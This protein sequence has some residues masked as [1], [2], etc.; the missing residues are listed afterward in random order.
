MKKTAFTAALEQH[1]DT[2]QDEVVEITAADVE[3]G[4]IELANIEVKHEKVANE[5]ESAATEVCEDTEAATTEIVALESLL[6]TVSE[7]S[8]DG[9]SPTAAR[10]MQA[11]LTPSQERYNAHS[12]YTTLSIECFSGRQ[13]STSTN[14]SMEGIKEV[15]AKIIAWVKEKFAQFIAWVKRKFGEFRKDLNVLSDRVQ[16]L[17]VAT[18][19]R[20][21]RGVSPEGEVDLGRHADRIRWDDKVDP[22][23]ISANMQRLGMLV[24]APEGA[25]EVVLKN[26]RSAVDDSVLNGREIDVES[27]LH[28]PAGW[29]K[30]R[31]DKTG[32]FDTYVTYGS[33]EFPG[34]RLVLMGVSGGFGGLSAPK[35]GEP[36]QTKKPLRFLVWRAP[37]VKALESTKVP[38]LSTEQ[39]QKFC[40][41]ADGAINKLKGVMKT[42]EDYSKRISDALT[43]GLKR[44]EGGQYD[45]KESV[46][47][48]TIN[49]INSVGNVYLTDLVQAC[50]GPA[51]NVI[52]SYCVWA[53]K[54]A[55]A[56]E[57]KEKA[58]SAEAT[59]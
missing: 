17:K 49:K 18:R 58:A 8:E 26:I 40:M 53:E 22:A 7:M 9:M 11:A 33:P 21:G 48:G 36:T 39:I 1:D 31:V 23:D 16:K 52:A 28:I 32:F 6:A 47:M 51:Y 24:D 2:A 46:M 4:E 57:A 41:D 15:I 3:Q 5:L 35:V 19:R 44:S 42:Y 56:I 13:A 55:A 34:Q 43:D 30:I 59:A 14:V 12:E 20:T 25:Y 10:L 29:S 38:Y 37:S 45:V 54:S 50:S 27:H